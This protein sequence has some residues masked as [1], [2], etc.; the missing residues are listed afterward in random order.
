MTFKILLQEK[1]LFLGACVLVSVKHRNS[2]FLGK[3]EGKCGKLT[4]C[5]KKTKENCD[6]I[7]L[8]KKI[9]R[10]KK[11]TWSPSLGK[12]LP[13]ATP[14]PTDHSS[15]DSFKS[16]EHRNRGLQICSLPVLLFS[17]LNAV[18]LFH[19]HPALKSS[20]VWGQ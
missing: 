10:P 17:L 11:K 8:K 14:L 4:K 20:A 16:N 13:S 12:L 7:L 3:S 9:K 18:N 5:W 6:N 15:V 19:T 1:I 2:S